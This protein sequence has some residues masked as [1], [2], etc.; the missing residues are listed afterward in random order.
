M[1]TID[2]NVDMG[3]GFGRW[4]LGD[5]EAL[6]PYIS[7]ANIACG[8]HAG[9]P[10]IMRRTVRAAV[11][12][13]LDIGA[14]VALPDLLGFGRR[15][16]A[17]SAEEIR[18]YCTYQI[19]ALWAFVKSEGGSLS[20]VKPHGVLYAMINDSDENADALAAAMASIDPNLMLFLL[21]DRTQTIVGRHGIRLITEGFVDLDYDGAGNLL[22]ERIKT[23][24]D[25]EEVANRALRL[26][27]EHKVIAKD[28][29][30]LRIDTPTICLHGD[31]PN[32]L[33]VVKAVRKRLDEAGVAI[34]SVRKTL[35]KQPSAQAVAR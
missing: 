13:G 12:H 30:E 26:A 19:G 27:I 24:R 2:L 4:T 33:D 16:M 6:M 32:A 35:Q 10:S 31:A 9:D 8:F 15:R 5:D 23:A 34:A 25:P 1:H 7:S 11:K 29:T 20:Y 3:E 21:N 28:G 17:L 22:I 18:D 14:H